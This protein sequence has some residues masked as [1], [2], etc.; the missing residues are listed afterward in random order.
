MVSRWRNALRRHPR[1]VLI[2][3]TQRARWSELSG[4]AKFLIENEGLVSALEKALAKAPRRVTRFFSRYSPPAPRRRSET[5]AYIQSVPNKKLRKLFRR[6]LR[7]VARFGVA[8]HIGKRKPHFK[9][10]VLLPPGR[11]FHVRLSGNHLCPARKDHE[12][13]AYF[14][15]VESDAIE[16][17]P[18]IEKLI[19]AGHCKFVRVDDRE[20]ASVFSELEEFAYFPEGFTFVAH[21]AEQPYLLCL[22][23]EKATN[24]AWRAAGRVIHAFQREYYRQEKAGR[25]ADVSKLKRA[26]RLLRKQGALKDKAIDLEPTANPWSSQVYFARIRSKLKSS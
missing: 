16:A 13:D 3:Q 18:G 12:S 7:Y 26:L 19:K 21:F 1:L 17:L 24:V 4:D 22:V 15:L 20:A 5:L 11:K 6:Y 8:L 10:E 25:P 14:D 2:R 9:F 23:G